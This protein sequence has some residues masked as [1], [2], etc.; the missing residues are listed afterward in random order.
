MG[1]DVWAPVKFRDPVGFIKADDFFAGIDNPQ[2]NSWVHRPQSIKYL[3]SDN[4]VNSNLRP[5]CSHGRIFRFDDDSL[6]LIQFLRPKVWRI[7]FHEVNK[8]P[9]DF[10]D[11]NT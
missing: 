1:D 10:T 6:L 4:Y 11:F 5:T 9:D 2:T 8:S 3:E 7:R